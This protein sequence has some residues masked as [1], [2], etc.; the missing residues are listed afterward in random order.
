MHKVSMKRAG[1]GKKIYIYFKER[2]Y[3]NLEFITLQTR[4]LI[5]VLCLLFYYCYCYCSIIVIVLCLL[6]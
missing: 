2:D 5:N 3:L 6:F 1:R 4:K